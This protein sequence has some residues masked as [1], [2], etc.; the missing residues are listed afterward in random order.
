ME[1]GSMDL[2]NQVI[3][4]N[5][6]LFDAIGTQVFVSAYLAGISVNRQQTDQAVS[7][8]YE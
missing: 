7:T 4:Q 2:V 5:D 8:C 1:P 6:Y 3:S